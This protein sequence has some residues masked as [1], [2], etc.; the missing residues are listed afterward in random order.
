MIYS[1]KQKL[2]ESGGARAALTIILI[3]EGAKY[4]C[5]GQGTPGGL[6]HSK[7]A[8]AKTGQRRLPPRLPSPGGSPA[9]LGAALGP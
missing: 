8:A 7:R 1:I 5:P 2:T 3:S 4:E 9:R 6:A